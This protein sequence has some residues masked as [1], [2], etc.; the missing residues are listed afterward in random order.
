MPRLASIAFFLLLAI[1]ASPLWATDSY[2]LSNSSTQNITE[3]STCKRVTNNHASGL[4]LFIP[5]K[6]NAEWTSFYTSPPP[7]VTVASC[8]TPGSQNYTTAG[9][10]SFTVPA[11]T[12]LTVQVWGGGG[13]GGA[14][15]GFRNART[16][17]MVG[18]NLDG[19]VGGQSSWN[20][21]LFANGGNGGG[22]VTD[23]FGASAAAGA[24]GTA[25]GGTTNTT[26][27]SGSGQTGGTALNGGTD[28]GGNGGATYSG[29]GASGGGGSGGYSTQTY[30]AGQ[31]TVGASITVVVG[32]VGAA[33]INTYYGGSYSGLAGGGGQVYIS[34]N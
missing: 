26:G 32:D 18:V 31:L 33:G 30:S 34:W 2:T 8:V 7:G 23:R 29:C 3:W 11:Y 4:S 12:T 24:G 27:N 19:G 28:Y 10:Y 1:V 25:S 17:C 9:T 6:T 15:S 13:G 14:G 20:S 16:G 21:T 22:G 5:T